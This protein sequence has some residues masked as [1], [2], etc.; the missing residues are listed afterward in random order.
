M[1]EWVMHDCLMSEWL[2]SEW[3]MSDWMMF[4]WVT[5]EWLISEW[6]ISEWTNYNEESAVTCVVTSFI[7]KSSNHVRDL[8]CESR[9]L[10]NN[11]P[12]I[13]IQHI[14]IFHNWFDSAGIH[15]AIR[16]HLRITDMTWASGF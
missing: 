13:G 11:R 1:S 6:L 15:T 12:S 10:T 8:V 16:P 7:C 14:G 5:A 9:L 2:M 4:G 3:V